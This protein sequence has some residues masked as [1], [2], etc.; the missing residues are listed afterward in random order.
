MWQF[1]VGLAILGAIFYLATRGKTEREEQETKGEKASGTP[2]SRKSAKSRK[3][4]P[5]SRKGTSV[6]QQANERARANGMA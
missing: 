2:T 6:A 3:R 5:R 4:S 1:L